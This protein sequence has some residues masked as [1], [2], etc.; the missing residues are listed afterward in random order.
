MAVCRDRRSRTIQMRPVG[1]VWSGVGSWS[2]ST[3]S[4]L[5]ARR[6]PLGRHVGEQQ[7]RGRPRLPR[8]PRVTG[9]SHP[10]PR[11]PPWRFPVLGLGLGLDASGRELVALR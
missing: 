8:L 3:T 10:A 7:I 4:W 1:R 6:A 5:V 2:S 11:R 9:V